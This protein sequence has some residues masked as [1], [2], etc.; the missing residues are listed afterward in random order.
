MAKLKILN[1]KLLDIMISRLCQQL[2][3]NHDDFQETVLLG[4]QPKGI[5]LAERIKQRLK[6]ITG[7]ELPL[8]HLDTT[9]FRDDFRR[10]SEPLKPNATH[11]PFI[12]ENK[13]VVLIDDVLFTGRSVRAAIDA[14]LAFGRP[15]CIEL[16]VLIDR[17]YSRDLP[18]EP[19]YVGKSVNTIQ[20]QRVQVEWREQEHAEDNV[21]LVSSQL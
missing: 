21:W 10:R 1:S 8:G 5:Y 9:F 6:E 3:E 17:K 7:T 16:L 13:K 2:V 14:M 15:S 20:S 11:V 4:M 18:I 12:I 19:H